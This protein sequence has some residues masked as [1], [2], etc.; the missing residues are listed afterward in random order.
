M[1]E[2][3]ENISSNNDTHHWNLRSDGI[4]SIDGCKCHNDKGCESCETVICYC[5]PPDE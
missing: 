3:I 5:T 1:A 2:V 4:C